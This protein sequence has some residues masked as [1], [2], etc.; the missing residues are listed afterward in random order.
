[1]NPSPA[2][3]SAG[4]SV[5]TADNLN[6]FVQTVSTFA[7][8][9]NFPA[10]SNMVVQT[11]GGNSVADGLQGVFYYNSSS[12]ATDNNLSVIVPT[13][14]IQG[15]WLLIS[16]GALLAIKITAFNASGLYTPTTGL[17]YATIENLGG[18]GGGGGVVGSSSGTFSGGG[19]GAGE[20]RRG[21][22][23]SG[24]IGANQTITIGAAGAG[25]ASGA[26]NGGTG[27]T[28]S[29]GTLLTAF[30][31][32]GGAFNQSG[33]GFGAGGLGGTGGSGGAF[34]VQG[35]SGQCGMSFSITTLIG[36]G[37]QGAA[38]VFGGVSQSQ[39]AISSANAGFAAVGYGSGGNG[40]VASAT[41]SSAAGGNGSGGLCIVTEY[42]I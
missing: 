39:I 26:N 16:G 25:G 34:S 40:A 1:M 21:S 32:S 36:I 22:F 18:G 13:G 31:G 28:T 41:T 35:S 7:D 11:Q 4:M 8:L 2:V 27:G 3:F 17:I 37:A 30:G 6:T 10:L 24:T 9:R 12:V 15:A 14:N 29:F 20:Y 38:S 42:Y 33:S 5:V 19:G 23:S